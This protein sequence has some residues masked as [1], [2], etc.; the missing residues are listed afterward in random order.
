LFV[1]ITLGV[2]ASACSSSSK[3]ASSSSTTSAV[4]VPNGGTLVLGLEQEP[5]CLDWIGS[6]AGNTY[7]YWAANVTTMPRAFSVES[8]GDGWAYV[9]T[10]VLA[11]E[12]ALNTSAKQTVTYKI[13]PKAVWSDGQAI[14]SHDFKYT[15]DQIAHGQDI[16]DQTGYTEIASVDDS[17]PHVA[18]VTFSSTVADWKSLF[19]G[20]YGLL[21]AHLL[22]GKDRA[23]LMADGYAWSGGP[24]KIESWQKGSQITLVPNDAYWGAKPKL[25]KVTFKFISDT[26]AEFQAFKANEVLGIYPQ[27]QV[28]VLDQITGDAPGVRAQYS[29]DTAGAEGLWFNTSKAPFNDANVRRAIGYSLDRDAIV[30]RLFGKIG[31]N[32][33]LQSFTPPVLSSFADD[34]AFSA[35]KVDQTQV[36]KLMKASGWAKGADGIWAKGG[37]KATFSVKAP[38]GNKRRDL[39]EQIVQAQLKTA[40]FDMTI[41]N[42]P[43]PS[44]GKLL[45]QGDFQMVLL[46]FSLSSFYPSGCNV[47]CS[48]NIPTAANGFSGNNVFRVNDKKL[49]QHYG[50]V[51]TSLDQSAAEAANKLGDE[52]LAAGAYFMPLDPLPT[53]LLTSTKVVGS[54]SDNPVMGPFWMLH[55]WGLKQ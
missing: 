40:G 12:P 5:D 29:A 16:Y 43:P 10:N 52:A 28:D 11:G 13:N 25:D 9:P 50:S 31:V 54:V 6:C 32:K 55:T 22:E 42:Q 26:S 48:K 46:K 15:W 53:I 41:D 3:S 37:Q 1:V 2:V 33:A 20:N 36:D 34:E 21:P 18:V 14:T 24:W 39:T 38:A 23:K 17:D 45:A 51:E 27:P 30:K 4:P 19:G 49:D 35:Y 7:G 44:F 8:S 47:W